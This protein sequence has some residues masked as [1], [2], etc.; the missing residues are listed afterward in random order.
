MGNSRGPKRWRQE[1]LS[2]H[3]L[4]VVYLSAR[5]E[6][7]IAELSEAI[8]LTERYIA[9]IVSDLRS[10]GLIKTERHGSRNVYRVCEDASFYHPLLAGLPIGL[11]TA[12]LERAL[13][14]KMKKR[15]PLRIAEGSTSVSAG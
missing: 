11:I 13:R 10:D 4:V 12:P 8:G 5:P 7:T 15:A 6:V 1:V 14:N 3:G 2:T 9:K